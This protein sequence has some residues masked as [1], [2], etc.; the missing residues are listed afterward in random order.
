MGVWR[1]I[2]L[3]II[4]VG[5]MVL[6]IVLIMNN[7]EE[8]TNGYPTL[9][10]LG[11]MGSFFAIIAFILLLIAVMLKSNRKEV[12][13]PPPTNQYNQFQRPSSNVQP[14]NVSKIFCSSC[15]REIPLDAVMCPYCGFKVK[16]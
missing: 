11:W 5:L 4:G 13:N 7:L 12:T 16:K 2:E 8:D 1:K 14:Q 10:W 3:L 15:G 9:S 6:G